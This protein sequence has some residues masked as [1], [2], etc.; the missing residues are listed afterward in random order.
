MSR[1]KSVKLMKVAPHAALVTAVLVGAT[2]FALATTARSA[3][4]RALVATLNL[5]ET[6]SVRVEP[7]AQIDI[8]AV[9]ENTGDETLN[10]TLIDADA[11]TPDNTGDD[12]ILTNPSGDT[13]GDGLLD[14]PEEWTYSG[15][16]A[17]PTE[18]ATNIVGV[19]AISL[20]GEN[21]SDIASCETDVVQQAM[22]GEIAGVRE[23]SGRVLIKE[24][25]TGRF[26]E[27]SG[28][29]EIPIG[30]QLNTLNGTVRLTAG[31]GGG[32]TNSAN[33]YQGVFTILQGRARGAFMTLRLDGGNFRNC[34]RRSSFSTLSSDARRKRPVRRLWG[35]GKGRFTTRGRYSSATVRGT[36]WLTL[37]RCDG[38]LTRVLQGIVRVRNLRTKKTINVRAGRSY[39]A[40]APGA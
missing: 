36:K 13:D 25:G 32:Q 18:D 1:L 19:D 20:G 33:F 5:S 12:F 37:D 31:L 6:C 22:P 10:I 2:L 9:V 34:G 40:R 30:S 15:S 27:L 4:H 35:S 16:Y 14:P 28:T 21:V 11:G 7:A 23:V 3:P 38:T 29:T 26:V 39:L 24:P 17:A 8:Q